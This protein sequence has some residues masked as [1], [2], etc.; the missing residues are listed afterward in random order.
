MSGKHLSKGFFVTVTLADERSY[1]FY[2][3]LHEVN[4]KVQML[5]QVF[6]EEVL[7]FMA[8]ANLPQESKQ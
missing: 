3:D 7:S 5:A 6:E 4:A 8:T 1:H 2:A